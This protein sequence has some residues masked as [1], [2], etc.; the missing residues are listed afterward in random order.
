[1]YFDNLN[2]ILF[3]QPDRTIKTLASIKKSL[4]KI[5]YDNAINIW[6]DG[7]QG[8]K[9]EYRKIK[10]NTHEV[11]K[12]AK[13]IFPYSKLYKSSKNLGIA[14]IYNKAEK[15]SIKK[16][17]AIY[18][19]FFEDD[20][21]V[22]IDYFKALKILM[23]WAKDKHEIALVNATGLISYSLRTIYSIEKFDKLYETL[24]PVHELW[25]YA[26]KNDHLKERKY[27]MEAYLN[28][29]RNKSY[30][31]RDNILLKRFFHENNIKNIR[32]YSQDYAK[33]AAMVKFN[34]I[35]IT[36]PRVYLGKY[37]GVYGEHSN[38]DIYERLQYDKINEL[39]FNEKEYKNF[40]NKKYSFE[41]IKLLNLYENELLFYISHNKELINKN[42]GIIAII[43]RKLKSF[44]KYSNNLYNNFLYLRRK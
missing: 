34:K 44:F 14:K 19:L 39:V 29:M 36:V 37:I 5:N 24:N 22:S 16:S 27:F 35:G 25:A 8:S 40:L 10:D 2:I 41:L 33:K 15:L 21:E 20:Y 17:N 1:M 11:K 26:I 7:Y 13:E 43:I 30:W 28:T 12:I 4:E 32:S 18:S 31:E 6:I 9:D 42:K 23:E 38:K 3:N